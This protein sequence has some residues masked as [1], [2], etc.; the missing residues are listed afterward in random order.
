MAPKP[1]ASGSVHH[2]N[3]ISPSMLS[4]STAKIIAEARVTRSHGHGTSK[5]CGPRYSCRSR[6]YFLLFG[7]IVTFVRCGRFMT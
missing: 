6:N 7:L 4:D 5:E 2:P 3:L 1:T